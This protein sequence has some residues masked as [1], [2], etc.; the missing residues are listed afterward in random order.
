[1]SLC[2]L[3]VYWQY[4]FIL[5]VISSSICSTRTAMGVS[6]QSFH[7]NTIALVLSSNSDL[8]LGSFM[9]NIHSNPLS[10][11]PSTHL[12]YFLSFSVP[13]TQIFLK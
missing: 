2:K 11:F 13:I 9:E 4:S 12:P 6:I 8:K 5:S 7:R 1:M 3:R 10:T